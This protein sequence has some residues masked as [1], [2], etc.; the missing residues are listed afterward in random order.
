MTQYGA[1]AS[2]DFRSALAKLGLQAKQ[3]SSSSKGVA[4]EGEEEEE[5]SEGGDDGLDADAVKALATEEALEKVRVGFRKHRFVA[6][7]MPVFERL[8]G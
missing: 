7:C 5:E 8:S 6:S 1:K 3:P 2:W 4:G